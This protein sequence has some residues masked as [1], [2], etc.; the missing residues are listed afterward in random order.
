MSQTQLGNNSAHAEETMFPPVDHSLIEDIEAFLAGHAVQASLIA[1]DGT[2]T[3]IPT[4]VYSVLKRVVQAMSQGSAVTVAPV[5]M[6]L[7]TSQAA[8]MLG[9]SRPTLIRLLEDGAIPY[10][11]PRR[12]RILRLD[13]V[14]AFKRNQDAHRAS[15][16][17]ELTRQAVADGLYD[18]SADQFVHEYRKL[19]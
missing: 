4:E 12:H 6:R 19:A 16:L 10:D 1:P 11:Q 3:D 2:R 9:I 14:L 13:D 18:D 5:S 15:L 8:D 7:T 17:S